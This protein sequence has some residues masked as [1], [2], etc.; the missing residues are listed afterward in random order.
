MKYSRKEIESNHALRVERD[1]VHRRHGCDDKKSHAFILSKAL[2]LEGRVLEI[3]TGK[4]RFL[5]QLLKHVPRVTTIDVDPAEQRCARLNVAYE[6]PPGR[7]RFVIADARALPW[8]DASFD[9]VV[10]VNALHHMTRIP[11]VLREILRVV[12]PGGKIVLAD[13]SERGFAIMDRIHRSEGRRHLRRPY[14]FK[15]IEDLLKAQ[16]WRP[17][18][19][20]GGGQVALVAGWS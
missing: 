5:A 14:H 11:T 3:G 20:R 13:F 4:G 8:K 6:K 1:A 19:F 16:G 10:S 9:A 15:T 12:R 18:R 2:P 7:A 17:R